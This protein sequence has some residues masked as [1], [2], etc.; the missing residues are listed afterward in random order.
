ME[1]VQ[2]HLFDCNQCVDC[3]EWKPLGDY[4]KSNPRVCRQCIYRREK[5]YH[6]PKLIE[7]R[8][9]TKQW[10][11]A[12]KTQ[13]DAARKKW[14]KVNKEKVNK[15]TQRRRALIRGNGGSYTY[16]EWDA[17]CAKYDHRCLR[18][19]ETKRLTPDHIIPVT[20][21]GTSFIANIQPLCMDCN[22][23]KKDKTIDYRS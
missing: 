21:G 1:I 6:A 17:L 10:Q 13:Y 11:R 18:C 7:R 20:K 12:N 16:Q 19:G 2:L 15:F 5:R 22:Q 4:R 9:K 8:L 23:R 3:Q 14:R